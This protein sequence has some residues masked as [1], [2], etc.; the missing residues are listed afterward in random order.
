M[1]RLGSAL[2][3][4]VFIVSGAAQLDAQATAS[5]TA[6]R[7]R[8]AI[9]VGR[10]TSAQ[11]SWHSPATDDNAAEYAWQARIGD[12][13]LIG[14]QLFKFPDSKPATGSFAD[15][16]K[17]GQSDVAEITSMG[18][19][20]IRGVTPAL[21]G[22][23]D[24]LVVELTDKDI[25]AKLFASRPRTVVIE[26]V[27]PYSKH[28]TVRVPINYADSA[29]RTASDPTYF[30]ALAIPPRSVGT[31]ISVAPRQASASRPQLTRHKLVISSAEPGRRREITVG[32]DTAGRVASY[33]ELG[34]ASTSLLSAEGDDIIATIDALGNRHGWRTHI[35]TVIP[36]SVLNQGDSTV[37]RQ[38]QKS[39]VSKTSRE[40]L[41]DQSWRRVLEIGDWLRKRCP[42]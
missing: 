10:S 35:T 4:S 3:G 34:F 30:N 31:C 29:A 8:I 33:Y 6:D 15:L 12:Q 37:L 18:G 17:A 38:L 11:W 9:P 24:Q 42:A 7:V 14:F 21:S 26:T 22:E 36:D 19:R 27:S 13:Y 41:D 23:R 1:S 39:G 20:V 32:V 40:P 16:L 2:V 28:R 25:I 5:V